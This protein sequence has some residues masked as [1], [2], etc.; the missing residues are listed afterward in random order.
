MESHR[1]FAQIWSRKT[2]EICLEAH[3]QPPSSTPLPLTSHLTLAVIPL[4]LRS[5]AFTSKISYIFHDL[6][7]L[8][9]PLT[10]FL[11]HSKFSTIVRILCMNNS[12]MLSLA[13][14]KIN[15]RQ[16]SWPSI[17]NQSSQS[18]ASLTSPKRTSSTSNISAS[19][20]TG[21]IGSMATRRY[22][23]KFLGET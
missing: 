4:T 17:S 9:A 11:D 19:R 8:R 23:G 21:I 2:P 3:A 12:S 1:R 6:L 18:S 14:Y 15:L 7:D 16:T 5:S 13:S 22:I 20:L 10:Q